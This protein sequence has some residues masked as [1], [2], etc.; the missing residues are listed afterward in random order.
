M[1]VVSMNAKRQRRPNVRLGE[2]GEVPAAFACGF[3]EKPRENLRTKR[4]KHDDVNPK[5]TEFEHTNGFPKGRSF[6]LMDSNP[7]VS[8]RVSADFHQ[9]SENKNPNSSK[10]A[11]D[12]VKSNEMNAAMDNLDFTKITRKCRVMKRTGRSTI[13]SGGFFSGAWSPRLSPELSCEKDKVC[14]GRQ[15]VQ[16]TSDA[17]D[18]HSISNGFKDLSDHEMPATSKDGSE[19]NAYETTSPQADCQD[20][21]KEDAC[22]EDNSEFPGLSHE[23]RSGDDD[24][25]D[26]KQWLEELGFGKYAALFEMHEVDEEVLPLLTLEDLKEIGVFAVGPRRKLYTAIQQLKRAST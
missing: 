24:T 4:W 7:E 20:L 25:N 3:P 8:P 6:Q 12:F 15:F 16:F 13:Y 17:S 2:V 18:N 22:E 19:Y 11:L 10:S 9:N 14:D 23:M 21:G 5:E 26:V 1:L